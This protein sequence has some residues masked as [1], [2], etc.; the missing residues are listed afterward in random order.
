MV[1]A[2]PEG[3]ADKSL[4]VS[5]SALVLAC[6]IERARDCTSMIPSLRSAYSQEK[7]K[8]ARR[9]AIEMFLFLLLAPSRRPNSRSVYQVTDYLHD[10][11]TKGH[12]GQSNQTVT[13]FC[14]GAS[15]VKST[16]EK[17]EE[18]HLGNH[19]QPSDVCFEREDIEF[20]T[21]PP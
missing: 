16:Q 6:P 8:A 17:E 18:K 4:A 9:D 14:H 11:H 7:T 20:L 2:V 5:R 1:T 10:G 12:R 15:P 3:R 19:V 21:R 13:A